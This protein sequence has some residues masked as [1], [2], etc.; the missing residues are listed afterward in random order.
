MCPRLA[1]LNNSEQR[2]THRQNA[3]DSSILNQT[4]AHCSGHNRELFM[5]DVHKCSLSHTHTITL[6]TCWTVAPLWLR[7]LEGC[8]ASSVSYSVG[9]PKGDVTT[10]TA[11][12]SP[13]SPIV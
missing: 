11:R 4:A 6:G 7:R 2:E 9:E 1:D 12:Q 10:H 3:G 13:A 5:T 8:H